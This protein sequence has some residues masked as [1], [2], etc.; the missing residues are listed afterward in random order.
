MFNN[1]IKHS[2]NLTI[3][4]HLNTLVAINFLISIHK[5][6]S[7]KVSQKGGNLSRLF[8]GQ[9]V[10]PGSMQLFHRYLL[11]AFTVPSSFQLF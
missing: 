4:L 1:Y 5:A 8:I 6:Y 7:Q 3:S 11:L 10:P 9:N 2:H